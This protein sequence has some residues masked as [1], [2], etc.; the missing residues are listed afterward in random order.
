MYSV[1]NDQET[2]EYMLLNKY[3]INRVNADISLIVYH[4]NRM[5]C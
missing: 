5:H 3:K 2:Y 4:K 1:I